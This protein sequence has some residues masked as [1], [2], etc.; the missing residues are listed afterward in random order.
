LKRQDH[1]R[2]ETRSVVALLDLL[3]KIF[4]T[5]MLRERT[6]LPHRNGLAGIKIKIIPGISCMSL[7]R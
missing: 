3:S 2:S 4:L 1:K 5:R 6:L 7:I